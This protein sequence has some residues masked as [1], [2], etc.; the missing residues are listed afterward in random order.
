MC[1]LL[2]EI[3]TFRGCETTWFIYK[4]L[5]DQTKFTKKNHLKL[6]ARAGVRACVCVCVASNRGCVERRWSQMRYFGARAH[7]QIHISRQLKANNLYPRLKKMFV[8]NLCHMK[9]KYHLFFHLLFVFVYFSYRWRLL[10]N[11]CIRSMFIESNVLKEI[12]LIGLKYSRIWTLHNLCVCVC[13]GKCVN[14]QICL[15]LAQF[16]NARELGCPYLLTV[17]DKNTSKHL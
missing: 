14:R 17:N 3:S 16:I 10:R 15:P 8:L 5:I 12:L 9:R 1:T 6:N 4:F 7:E 2:L 11:H 13:C